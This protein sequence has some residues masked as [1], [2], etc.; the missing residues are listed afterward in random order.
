MKTEKLFDVVAV[1]LKTKAERVIAT[2]RDALNAEAVVAMAVARHGCEKE[3]F[4]A[5]PA[6]KEAGR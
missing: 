5:V 4:K 6:K 1:D 2:G 3:F